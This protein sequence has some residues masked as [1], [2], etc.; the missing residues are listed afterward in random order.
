MAINPMSLNKVSS[1]IQVSSVSLTDTETK[2][3]LNQI[4]SQQQ[5]LN[6]LSSDSKIS[7]EERAKERQEIQ[8][9]I[10]ELN[11]KLRMLRLEKKEEAK[12][13]EK[14]QKQKAAL[15]EKLGNEVFKKETEESDITEKE[16]SKEISI[17]PQNVQKLLE[18]GTLLL[19]ER[20]RQS[21]EQK[22]EAVQN[23]MESEIASDKIY[24]TD[25]SKKEEKLSD[26]NRKKPFELKIEERQQEPK[27]VS[28]KDAPKKIVIRDDEI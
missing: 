24:G 28:F 22:R 27:K 23:V 3:I 20:I 15:E 19:K 9:Q 16:D 13:A 14:E 8:K 7:A 26:F 12:E 6:R 5:N 21:V 10:A 11:R 17:S 25:T 18:A 1:N 4:T 2:N